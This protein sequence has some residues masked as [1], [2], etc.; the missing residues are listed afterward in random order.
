[1]N[2][3]KPVYVIIVTYNGEKWIVKCIQS[4]LE[5]DMKVFPVIIDNNSKDRTTDI[6]ETTFPSVQLIKLENN[7]GFG[8][9]NNIGMKIAIKNSA[10]FLFLMNQDAWITPCT[11]RELVNVSISFPEYGILSPFHLSGDR[12]RL[13]DLFARYLANNTDIR[14][15]S[16]LFRCRDGMRAVYDTQ[17]VNA[18]FWLMTKECVQKVGFFDPM[19]HVY[20]E[21]ADYI[22]RLLAHEFRVGICVNSIAYHDRQIPTEEQTQSEARIFGR[23][24]YKAK[25]EQKKLW[26]LILKCSINCVKMI[27]FDDPKYKYRVKAIISIIREYSLLSSTRIK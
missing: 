17:F 4:I 27:V 9:A 18:A 13:D 14:L 1:M 25:W 11:I 6:I 12:Q 7:V 3:V 16:D 15:I 26:Q 5:S 19:F 2:E 20:G 22:R 23:E 8:K 10:D 21:D 24:L